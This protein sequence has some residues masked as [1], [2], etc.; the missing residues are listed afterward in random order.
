MT[1]LDFVEQYSDISSLSFCEIFS[2]LL[3]VK[4]IIF[5]FKNWRNDIIQTFSC[6]SLEQDR[7][8]CAK[9][10]YIWWSVQRYAIP[11]AGERH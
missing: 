11:S 4:Y 2:F 5:H 3:K 6:N 1:D 7:V 9:F 8:D 10:S